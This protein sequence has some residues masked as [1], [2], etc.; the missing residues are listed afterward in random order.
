LKKLKKI[1]AVF[2]ATGLI[3]STSIH[4]LANNTEKVD[5]SNFETVNL[6]DGLTSVKNESTS[7]E[8]FQVIVANFPV[9]LSSSNIFALS[10]N[11]EK[12]INLQAK[13]TL[14]KNLEK[15][16]AKYEEKNNQEDPIETPVVKEETEV[17][18][19]ASETKEND[20]EKNV[21]ETEETKDKTDKQ[22]AYELK[23]AEKEAAK[24]ARLLEKQ[25]RKAVQQA[26]KE[27][28][29]V[30]KQ[31]KK[32]EHKAIQQAKKVENKAIQHVKKEERKASNHEKRDRKDNK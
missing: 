4:V 2:L 15:A 12:I 13:S 24:A 28:H 20:V 29:K 27:E 23:K 32:E 1:S 11:I 19:N 7:L 31:A 14:Q 22:L 3:A 26:K 21:P 6:Q 9:G 30:T 17:E 5:T 18:K 25:E 10:T 16:M 8:D